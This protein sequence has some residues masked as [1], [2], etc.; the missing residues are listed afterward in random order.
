M[1][2]KKGSERMTDTEYLLNRDIIEEIAFSPG[3]SSSKFL[4]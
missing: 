4:I 1:G 2:S 3:K